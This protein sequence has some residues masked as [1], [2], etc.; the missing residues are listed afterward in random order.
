MQM[1]V[2]ACG[3]G[4]EVEEVEQVSNNKNNEIFTIIIIHKCAS[5]SC[6]TRHWRKCVLRAHIKYLRIWRFRIISSLMY[7]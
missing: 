6:K 1:N 2:K 3:M 7:F 5:E 4:G